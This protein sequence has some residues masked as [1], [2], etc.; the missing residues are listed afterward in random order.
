MR[1][2]IKDK[3]KFINM[4]NQ[5]YDNNA[6][7][8]INGISIDSRKIMKDDIYFPIKGNNFDGHNFIEESLKLGA[9]ICFSK[10]KMNNPKIINT[11]SVRNEINKLCKNWM[12]LSQVKIIGITGS[13]GKTT[14]KNLL[15]HILK[16]Q[17]SCSK[18]IGN[19]NSL[20]GL[21]ITFLATSL[22]DKYCILEYGANKPNEI[23]FLCDVINPYFSYITNISSAH[24][25]NFNSIDEI[26]QTKTYL[27]KS[28]NVNGISFINTD[29]ILINKDKIK[30][31]ITT[32]GF[33]NKSDFNASILEKNNKY[34]LSINNKKI[35]IPKQLLHLKDTILAAYVIVRSLNI[36]NKVL[37]DS[38]KSFNLPRGRGNIINYNN[39]M[40]ID[41]SYN[42][43][44]A[45]VKLAIKRINNIE[46]K[47]KKILVLGDMLELGNIEL[48]AH[49]EI[50][51]IINSSTL[52]IIITY[53]TLTKKTHLNIIKSKYSKH[54]TNKSKLKIE[55]N[56]LICKN[57]LVYLKGSRSMELEKLYIEDK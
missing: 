38:I 10:N 15:Y 43:N 31:K 28:T 48:E 6:I 30:S 40:I 2:E 13:N 24:I 50:S 14:T 39:Y 20:I 32:F 36:N 46:I 54:Y 37:E 52:D 4:F 18:T 21:P 17:F 34:Y 29:K 26:Y 3:K 16:N 44:P 23:K 35:F 51:K 33:N 27:Y 49:K 57:D 1:I 45:S 42:A 9:S 22:N 56:N 5:L 7:T 55:L 53:G 19:F 8:N 41:D 47:G 11:N 12:K 25:K